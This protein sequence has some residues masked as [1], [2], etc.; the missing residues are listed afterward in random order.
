[1]MRPGRY[2]HRLTREM[3]ALVNKTSSTRVPREM[4]SDELWAAVA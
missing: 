1:M 3:Y 2:G 4:Y